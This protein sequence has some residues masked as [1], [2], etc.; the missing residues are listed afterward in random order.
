MYYYYGLTV[1]CCVHLVLLPVLPDHNR[2]SIGF[3][4]RPFYFIYWLLPLLQLASID[5]NKKIKGSL[6]IKS[7]HITNVS[8]FGRCGFRNYSTGC[9][10]RVITSM[11]L[12]IKHIIGLCL[13]SWSYTLLSVC[14]TFHCWSCALPVGHAVIPQRR[15]QYFTEA[16]MYDLFYK[17]YRC[18]QVL[19]IS[20]YKNVVIIGI[21]EMIAR[22]VRW[23]Q[24]SSISLLAVFQWTVHL[25]VFL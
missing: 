16:S 6:Q 15:K 20:W 22:F 13:P 19:N 2:I 14:F 4:F 5:K 23:K 8:M 25:F 12:F 17:Y 9:L 11:R 3:R 1:F 18:C 24:Q 10:L 7:R 21:A